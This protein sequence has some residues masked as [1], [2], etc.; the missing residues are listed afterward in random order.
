[1]E[2]ELDEILFDGLN[3]QG[4]ILQEKCS[5]EIIYT[6]KTTKWHVNTTEHPVSLKDHDTRIDIIIRELG[7]RESSKFGVIECKRVNPVYNC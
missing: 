2:R 1:M 3:E 5:E 4:F 7:L 6:S